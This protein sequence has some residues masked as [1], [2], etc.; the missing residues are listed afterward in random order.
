MK[1]M[2]WNVNRFNGTWDYYRK[3]HDIEM[4]ERIIYAKK[5]LGKLSEALLSLDDIAILQEVPYRGDNRE[6]EWERN[7]KDLFEDL[8]VMFWFKDEPE[9]KD[10][11]YNGTKNVT[12]AVTK[13]N[14]NWKLRPFELRAIKFGKTKKCWDYVNRYIELE[15]GELSLLG[16]YISIGAGGQLKAVSESK[17]SLIAGDFNYNSL[18]KDK[19]EE[20]YRSYCKLNQAYEQLI[21]ED[22]I[23]DNKT[24]AGIDKILINKSLSET[25]KYSICVMDYCFIQETQPYE[26][27][28]Y[29]D[30]NLC[31]SE[32]EK[33]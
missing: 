2:T 10:F 16:V 1:I 32:I 21:P 13:K 25:C 7:W 27:K 30:H 15:N 31:I 8:S 9:G 26:K 33:K 11:N 17:F 22:V 18:I 5:I 28:R 14:G 24:I 29:S 20:N 19:N 23:T 6:D 12:I 4:S 3:H